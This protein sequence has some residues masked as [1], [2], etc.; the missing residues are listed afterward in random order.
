MICATRSFLPLLIVSSHNQQQEQQEMASVPPYLIFLDMEFDG[1]DVKSDHPIELAFII[2]EEISGR[3]VCDYSHYITLPD[4]IV[5][6]RAWE[7]EHATA[8]A[9]NNISWETLQTK[10][11]AADKVASDVMKLIRDLNT[12]TQ[13]IKFY[14][15]NPITD[16]AFLLGH[17][18]VAEEEQ[19]ALPYLWFDLMSAFHALGQRAQTNYW[20]QNSLTRRFVKEPPPPRYYS[21]DNISRSCGL[22]AEDRPHSAMTG[23]L[24]VEKCY[25]HLIGFPRPAYNPQWRKRQRSEFEDD[26]TLKLSD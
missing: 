14:C 7:K 23:A 13:Q 24:Q 10:G 8:L 26:K 6:Q 17:V 25:E 12:R 22:S 5:D 1:L 19:K 18:I 4:A 20:Q 3:F 11:L 15:Q 16:Q 21:L 2:V 9:I